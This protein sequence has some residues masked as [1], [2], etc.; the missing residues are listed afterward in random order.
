VV[1]EISKRGNAPTRSARAPAL[2]CKGQYGALCTRRHDTPKLHAQDNGYP[3]PG[4]GH[5]T[6]QQS[7]EIGPR[8][9]GTVFDIGTIKCGRFRAPMHVDRV[10]MQDMHVVVDCA[11]NRR[12]TQC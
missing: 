2:D 3:N 7:A 5:S 4:G 9:Y 6:S 11:K 1:E 8:A 10:Y 12:S